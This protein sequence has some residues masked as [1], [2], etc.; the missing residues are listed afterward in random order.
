MAAPRQ[1][2][3]GSRLCLDLE[4]CATRFDCPNLNTFPEVLQLLL[5][6]LLP[7]IMTKD[8]FDPNALAAT[9]SAAVLVNEVF[10]NNVI[11]TRPKLTSTLRLQ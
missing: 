10:G 7:V 9:D 5:V 8:Y 6:F 3:L 2:R 11:T 4:V 1:E